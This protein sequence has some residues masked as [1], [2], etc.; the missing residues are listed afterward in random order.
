M[1]LLNKIYIPILLIILC[2]TPI[3]SES[4]GSNEKE[5]KPINKTIQK[6]INDQTKKKDGKEHWEYH[7]ESIYQGKDDIL[8]S[9]KPLKREKK[10]EKEA[11]KLIGAGPISLEDVLLFCLEFNDRIQAKRATMA[12]T[13]GEKLINLSR[14]LPHV[15]FNI[16]QQAIDTGSTGKQESLNQSFMVTQKL[17]EFGKESDTSV[18][19]R[20]SQREALF[21]YEKEISRVLSNVRIKFFT[22]LLRQQQIKERESLLEE[23]NKRYTKMRELEKVRRVLEVDVLTSRLNVLHEEARINALK[24]DLLRQKMDLMNLM[25]FPVHNTEFQLK[26]EITP[27]EVALD[28]CV[29]IALRRSTV[30]AEARAEFYEQRRVAR[31]TWWEHGPDIELQVK[32]QEDQNAAG[33]SMDRENGT[34][35]VSA[36]AEKFLNGPEADLWGYGEIMGPNQG[37]WYLDLKASLPVFQGLFALGKHKKER[38]ILRQT[39]YS[40]RAA[41]DSVELKVRK[42]YQEMLE[43]QKELEILKETATISH[44]RLKIQEKLKEIGKISDNELETFRRQFFMDQNAYYGKETELIHSQ[45]RLRHEMRWFKTDE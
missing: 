32:W 23:Y 4:A 15:N 22:I 21:G 25:G 16:D 36:F 29:D 27:F 5:T 45:E 18:T 2:I 9:R 11:E 12:S 40:L 20:K 13:Q 10:R 39:F 44:E 34:Y 37:G 14:F 3:S 43:V 41:A 24:R 19:L 30:I 35:G 6:K 26:G 31:R 33:I 1:L 17:L 7:K 8:K 38:A 28:S 42:A